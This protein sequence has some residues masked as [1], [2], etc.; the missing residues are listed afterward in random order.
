M[1]QNILENMHLN[2]E[3]VDPTVKETI[4]TLL[5]TIEAFAKENR[6]LRQQ[7]QHLKDEINRLKGE[8][9]KPNIK[10]NKDISSEKERQN[11]EKMVHQKRQKNQNLKIDCT[12]ICH[13]DQSKLPADAKFK[14]YKT[15]LV[16]GLKIESNNIL[17]KKEI[18]YSVRTSAHSQEKKTYIADLP[19]GHEGGFDPMIKSLAHIL[20]NIGNMSASKILDFFQNVGV[21]ISAGTISNMLIKNK[22]VFHQEKQKLVA[23]GLESTEYQQIDDT[24]SRV[25]GQNYHTHILCNPLKV[26]GPMTLFYPLSKLAKNWE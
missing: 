10:P 12:E 6:E 22:E 9:G 2:L 7:V 11:K 14:G 1:N 25:N 23:A 26:P 18:Y 20:K 8:H 24:K 15:T 17:F 16:Q 19:A 4:R 21:E 3:Q 5:N 13:L